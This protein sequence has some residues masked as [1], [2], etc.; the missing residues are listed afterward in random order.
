M[1]TLEEV[2]RIQQE[3]QDDLLKL[4]GV[5][6]VD[7]TQRTIEG[8]RTNEYVIRI[9]VEDQAEALRRLQLPGVIQGVHVEVVERRFG[10]A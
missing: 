1:K 8:H 5:T 3:V 7:V 4:A 6:G 10:L 9:F 2:I